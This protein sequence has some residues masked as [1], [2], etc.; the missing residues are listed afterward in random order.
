M[1]F[2]FPFL[3]EG[4]VSSDTRGSSRSNILPLLPAPAYTS[5]KP[6]DSRAKMDFGDFGAGLLRQTISAFTSSL[7]A[8][9]NRANALFAQV[10][11][12][13][14]FDRVARDAAAFFN[15]AWFGFGSRPSRP[16]IFQ[17]GWRP[18]TQDPM[19]FSPF[20]MQGLWNP[21]AANPW[22]AV[23]EGLKF[24]TNLWAP[25]PQQRNA[26]AFGGAKAA[27]PY[28]ATVSGPGGFTWGFS[29]GA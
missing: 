26:H 22:D 20:A 25:S 15:G 10:A 21:W 6:R 28:T 19:S 12:A 17:S 9:G 11:A 3:A 5:A 13:L 29:W 16:D 23:N 2:F 14:A 7:T 1:F 4:K 8:L 18:Q 24:W 27:N